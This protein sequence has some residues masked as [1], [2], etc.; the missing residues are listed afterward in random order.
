MNGLSDF[1][2]L[3]EYVIRQRLAIYYSKQH[4]DR[5]NI[6]GDI[7]FE[8]IILCNISKTSSPILKLFGPADIATMVSG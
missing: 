6:K 7:A 1:K 4:F 3:F 2:N 5:I 8:N